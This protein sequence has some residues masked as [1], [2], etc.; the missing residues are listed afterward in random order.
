MVLCLVGAPV[1]VVGIDQKRA[2]VSS[3]S[4][5]VAGIV[6]SMLEVQNSKL[7]EDRKPQV[8]NLEQ[9][10]KKTH[11]PSVLDG[12]A[13]NTEN[14]HMPRLDMPDVQ[15]LDTPEECEPQ[16]VDPEHQIGIETEDGYIMIDKNPNSYR[17][18]KRRS[19]SVS[20][21]KNQCTAGEVSGV[22]SAAM[23]AMFFAMASDA[24]NEDRINLGKPLKPTRA[25][26][27]PASVAKKDAQWVSH[28]PS[29]RRSFSTGPRHQNQNRNQASRGPRR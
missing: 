7:P 12:F 6:H 11:V 25:M 16:I 15:N 27:R 3:V 1:A 4:Q 9:I 20:R 5:E 19:R 8:F 26:S 10:P 17:K 13:E 23:A 29:G 18:S 24:T 14:V 28:Q 21:S 22:A 2:C